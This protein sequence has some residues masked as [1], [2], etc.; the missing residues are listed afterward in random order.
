M[1]VITMSPRDHDQLLAAT[2]HLPHLIAA[3]LSTAQPD[4]LP[5][6][7]PSFLD[8]TRIAK[9]DPDLWD[10]IFLTNRRPLLDAI[11][12]FDRQ[13]RLLRALLVGSRRAAL[14]RVLTNAKAK[15]DAFN[16]S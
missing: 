3:C 12:R 9:S 13:W 2:S 15:R 6:V 1:R 10:D 5:T 7:A 16:H 4:H 14:R 8:M 11:D